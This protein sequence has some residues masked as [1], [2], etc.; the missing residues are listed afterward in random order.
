[1]YRF[2]CIALLL[3]AYA[4][5][6]GASASTFTEIKPERVRALTHLLADEP[7]GTGPTCA[8]RSAWE[9]AD[10][11]VRLQE[12]TKAAPKIADQPVP[13][14]DDAAYLE[15]SRNGVRGNGER[16]MN[17]RKA[18]LHVLVLAE[19]AQW[20]GRYLPAITRLLQALTS[21]PTW[22]WAA[23]DKTLRSYRDH[24]YEVD[25]MA[26]DTAH[27]LGQALYVLG[28]K[29]DDATQAA[30]RQAIQQRVLDPVRRSYVKGGKDHWWLQADHNWNAVCLKGL[31]GA[32]LAVLAS[33]EDRAVFMAGAEHYIQRYLSGFPADGYALEG[34]GYWN[35]GFSHF[36]ELRELLMQATQGQLDLFAPD[37]VREIALY[38]YRYEMAPG[39]V[40][41]FGDAGRSTRMDD[42]TRAYANQA[43]QLGQ[44]QTLGAQPI[45][46]SASA[47]SSPLVQASLKLFAKPALALSAAASSSEP[48]GLHTLFGSVGVL[49][50]RPGSGETLGFAIK[51]GGNGNHSHN[52]VGSYAI[53]L[54]AEQPVGDAGATVYSS[55]T[56][57][58]ER[59]TI[60][61]INSW[62]HPVPVVGGQLQ[63]ESTKVKAPILAHHLDAQGGMVRIDMKPAYALATLQKLE[64]TAQH[65]RAPEAKISIE[66]AF[67]FQSPQTFETAIISTGQVELLPGNTID[68]WQKREHLL[69][70]VTA[71][72]PFTLSSE[73]VTEEGLTFTRVAVRLVQ[74]ASEGFVRIEFRPA[75]PPATP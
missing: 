7:S 50:S 27:E 62:G 23:H 38:G 69:A 45:G 36:V 35:Y 25:L 11:Q 29:L 20:Q 68:F 75:G 47:N 26:A 72:Q 10:V 64:R 34:P 1:M 28:S 67:R 41:L 31:T 17:A 49:V 58:K 32:A 63:Q 53:A 19:C 22:T 39:Q 66:D 30:V 54:G 43:L 56:F 73:T 5:C 8:D 60:R 61:G 14:W 42:F 52:D 46:A 21:Q 57:S 74:A 48:M 40:A 65:T 4:C 55:K 37:K 9:R 71:S 16:M 3:L 2:Q 51:A 70:T 18:G 59:F 13:A 12:V 24:N 6:V 44:P 15:Y 33:K